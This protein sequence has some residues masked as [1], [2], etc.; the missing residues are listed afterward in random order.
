MTQIVVVVTKTLTDLPSGTVFHNTRIT[1]TDNAGN[2]LDPA[3]VSGSEA[4][5]WSA[6][7]SGATGTSEATALIEDL[8]QDGNVIGTPITLTETGT[9]GQPAQQFPASSGGTITVTG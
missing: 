4:P 9:G 6:T 8:D 5:P 2:K 7:F 3:L 1:V